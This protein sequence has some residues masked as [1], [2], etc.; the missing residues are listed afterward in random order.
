MNDVPYEFV[1]A[2]GYL[3]P[4]FTSVFFFENV[5]WRVVIPL[6]YGTPMVNTIHSLVAMPAQVRQ[7]LVQNESTRQAYKLHWAD[8]LDYT[9]GR[10]YLRAVPP[11][12][13]TSAF[14]AALDRDLC[15]ALADLA[16]QQPNANSIHHSRLATE[17][18]FKA[19][20]C[21]RHAHT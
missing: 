9:Y 13:D 20:L 2:G 3:G 11:N 18:S 21:A 1:Q 4:D 5:F 6:V 19:L 10:D 15:S 16:Q 14:I 7:R 17:K 8:C 12:G